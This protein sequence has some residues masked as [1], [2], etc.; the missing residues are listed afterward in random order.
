MNESVPL[1][2]D[3]AGQRAHL[4]SDM[5]RPLP[6]TADKETQTSVSAENK[7]IS[8]KLVLKLSVA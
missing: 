3:L 1:L 6:D 4:T 5:G 2:P 8:L 7:S